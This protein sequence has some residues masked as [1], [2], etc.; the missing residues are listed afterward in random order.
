MFPWMTTTM[1]M[2]MMIHLNMFQITCIWETTLDFESPITSVHIGVGRE[3]QIGDLVPFQELSLLE[4]TWSVQLVDSI[5]D[6]HNGTAFV[7]LMVDN[8]VSMKLGF[9]YFHPFATL[10]YFLLFSCIIS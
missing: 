4:K 2:I 9:R 7:S 10:L 3:Q 6:I 5:F 8:T 1:I